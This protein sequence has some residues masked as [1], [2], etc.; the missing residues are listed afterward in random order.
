MGS[1][2]D[3]EHMM[4]EKRGKGGWVCPERGETGRIQ[5]HSSAIKSDA[6]ELKGNFSKQKLC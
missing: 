6:R 5:L 2:E 3:A 4:E 1:E